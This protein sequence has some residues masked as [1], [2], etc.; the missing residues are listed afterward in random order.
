MTQQLREK[1]EFRLL[2]LSNNPLGGVDIWLGLRQPVSLR[3][4]L[5]GVEGVADV[6]LDEETE[7]PNADAE[8]VFN[9]LLRAA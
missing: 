5:L 4:I 8:P 1:P 3:I 2:R 6:T 7:T 9:V